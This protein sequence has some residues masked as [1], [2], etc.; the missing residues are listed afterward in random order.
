MRSELCE[1]DSADYFIIVLVALACHLRWGQFV[2]I[3]LCLCRL[4]PQ[5]YEMALLFEV[6]RIFFSSVGVGDV[7][8]DTINRQKFVNR[9]RFWNVVSITV[10]HSHDA[11]LCGHGNVLLA[12]NNFKHCGF[13]SSD[14]CWN[15]IS[16]SERE[17]ILLC[18]HC[19]RG[20]RKWSA[21]NFAAL[22]ALNG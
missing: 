18:A 17:L 8:V 12:G 21:F 3:T 10:S 14:L 19:Q 20:T 1:T 22:W 16:S 11:V 7:P 5:F 6:S 4:S 13:N 9:Q 15:A 2:P